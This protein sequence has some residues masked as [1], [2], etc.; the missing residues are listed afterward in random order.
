MLV[1][2]HRRLFSVVVVVQGIVA[3]L[4]SVDFGTSEK[5]VRINAPL[6]ELAVA[7]LTA[8]F[9]VERVLG[10]QSVSRS[11]HT[12]FPFFLTHTRTHTHTHTL[13]Q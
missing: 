10:N 7:D 4:E 8:L 11:L 5:A 1:G 2:S 13:S 9:E 6:S 3:A 12:V